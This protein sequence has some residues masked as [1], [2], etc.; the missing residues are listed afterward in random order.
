[1]THASRPLLIAGNWK[2]Y[3]TPA[4]AARLVEALK[5]RWPA[6]A[7]NVALV[8]GPSFTSLPAVLKAAEGS[9]LEVA[10]Q[11]I[12]WADEGAFTGEVS[13]PMLAA[14][15]VSRVII[16][17]SERRQLFGETD[18]DI[19]KKVKAALKHGLKPIL[20]LGETLEQREEGVTFQVLAQ[21]LAAG[22]ADLAAESLPN[23]ALAYEPVWAIGTG[24]TASPEQ[25]QE[26]H[27]Y[28]RN[29]LAEISPGLAATTPLLYGGSVKPDNAAAL[30]AQPDLDGALVGGASLNAESFLAIARAG[31][32]ARPE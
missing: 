15:G 16:G 22:L 18:E 13:G 24:R 23:L 1:M 30:L 20:C 12:H 31:L 9:P 4:E 28:L 26:V 5:A 3:K 7:G 8:V 27:V 6:P 17:H 25:A 11:N 21:Q 32:E 14:L 10:A 29:R 2:M 19:N